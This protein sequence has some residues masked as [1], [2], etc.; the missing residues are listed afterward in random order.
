MT[1]W[2]SDPDEPISVRLVIPAAAF[3]YGALCALLWTRAIGWAI[4]AV[5]RALTS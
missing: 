1:R 2:N 4:D 5:T 3:V